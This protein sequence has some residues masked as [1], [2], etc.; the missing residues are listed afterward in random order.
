[1]TVTDSGGSGEPIFETTVRLGTGGDPTPNDGN[2]RL[3]PGL[4]EPGR[5]VV[6]LSVG[7]GGEG[8][9]ATVDATRAVGGEEDGV[10]VR[11]ALT[12]GSGVQPWTKSYRRCD[13]GK[14]P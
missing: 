6:T 3:D 8:T 1:M 13:E 10:L 4:A 5:Y 2:V 9:E 14:T 7:D 12:R 11:F